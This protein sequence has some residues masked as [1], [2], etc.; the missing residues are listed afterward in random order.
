MGA[1]VGSQVIGAIFGVLVF[2][3]LWQIITFYMQR[4]IV[5]L[6]GLGLVIGILWLFIER[7]GRSY[8]WQ[9][10]Y[11]TRPFAS[12]WLNVLN[13]CV[14]L[15]LMLYTAF[16]RLITLFLLSTLYIGRVDTPFIDERNQFVTQYCDSYHQLFVAGLITVEAHR[17][18]YIETLGTMLLFKIRHGSC[19]FV[20]ACFYT[21]PHAM[22]TKIPHI[23]TGKYW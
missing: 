15:V 8:A 23:D 2:S 22:V 16:A 12:N 1:L 21:N 17:H 4:L 19:W 14:A 5:F 7:L 9:A 6:V 18:P 20:A 10:F 11:R 13:E 3:S